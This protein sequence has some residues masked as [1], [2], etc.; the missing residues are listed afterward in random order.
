M[1]LTGASRPTGQRERQRPAAPVAAGSSRAS[2]SSRA[3]AVAGA[4]GA[5]AANLLRDTLEGHDVDALADHEHALGVRRHV[6]ADEARDAALEVR[7][8]EEHEV[9]GLAGEAA[10]QPVAEPEVLDLVGRAEAGAGQACRPPPARRSSA[11]G[12]GATVSTTGMPSSA[13]TSAATIDPTSAIR[14]CSTSTRPGGAQDPPDAAPRL[15]PPRPRRRR[16]GGPPPQRDRRSG[17][18]RA[19]GRR[20]ARTR[21]PSRRR[22]TVSTRPT[23]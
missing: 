14:R 9:R 21:R 3:A 15:D 16:T 12:S 18:P 1:P 23:R 8:G 2:S 19:R 6:D 10:Q 4:C 20:R 17:G 7:T 22:E 11:W 5:L 13:A